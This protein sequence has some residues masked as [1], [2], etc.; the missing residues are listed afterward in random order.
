MFQRK[1]HSHKSSLNDSIVSNKKNSISSKSKLDDKATSLGNKE[2]N[3]NSV[4]QSDK[5]SKCY[6]RTTTSKKSSTNKKTLK[7]VNCAY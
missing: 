3:R 6:K 2:N 5:S 1:T 7:K 4:V